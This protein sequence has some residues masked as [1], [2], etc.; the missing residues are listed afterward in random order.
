MRRLLG[1]SAV[2]LAMLTACPA[3]RGGGGPIPVAGTGCPAASSVF[4]ASY[5]TPEEG[6]KGHTGWVLPL[7]DKVVDSIANVP[8]Y[9]PID[10]AVAVA[11]GVPSPPAKVW[12]LGGAQP[13]Q[14]TV[15]SYYAA[16]IEAQTPNLA[17]GVE[18]A[19]CAAPPDPQNASAIVV[20]SEAAPSECQIAA[21]RSVAQRLGEVDKEGRWQRPTKQTPIPP[22]I[23]AAIPAKPCTAPGCEMLWSIAQVELGGKPVAWAGA[24][25]W[26]AIPDGAAP[27]TQ[28]EWKAETF[29][30]FFVAGA[31]G[32]PVKVTDAQDHPLALTAVLTDRT[33]AKVLVAEGPGEY[34]TYDLGGGNAQVGRHLVW[35]RPDPS[36]YDAIDHLGPECGD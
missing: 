32:T 5:L 19:G 12:L 23:T 6:A 15:G 7:H 25:N 2:A 16:A 18:L 17:Y 31:D 29:S 28:C 21:P 20:V 24:V 35:L 27:A 9:A 33:G 11:A 3:R 4:V 14:A 22:A 34:S 36:S 30:G 10:A 26:L 13:C 8:E 1:T